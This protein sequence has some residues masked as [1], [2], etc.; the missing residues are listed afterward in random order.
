VIDIQ[1][2]NPKHRINTS[3]WASPAHA[4]A[5]LQDA[6]GIGE[7][8]N[9][10]VK[11]FYDDKVSSNSARLRFMLARAYARRH[12]G[13]PEVVKEHPR[14]RPD[15]HGG[16]SLSVFSNANSEESGMFNKR[17]R[18][19]MSA[20]TLRSITMEEEELTND[21]VKNN[22]SSLHVPVH[23]LLNVGPPLEHASLV[24]KQSFSNEQPVQREGV[25]GAARV[26][27]TRL[28]SRQFHTFTRARS[29]PNMLD[30]NEDDNN[31]DNRVEVPV[32]SC[33]L[34]E[35]VLRHAEGRRFELSTSLPLQHEDSMDMGT[36]S[37]YMGNYCTSLG[38]LA[39][40]L[41]AVLYEE[42]GRA[43]AIER[44]KY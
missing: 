42:H 32:G 6:V 16:A 21:D 26:D 13:S 31:N 10:E 5:G 22:L 37:F 35:Q 19:S 23:H 9:S 24:T 36:L 4:V 44:E 8:L 11:L 3:S 29:V 1:T 40:A 33:Q 17:L 27:V 43:L 15:S 39:E 20:Y 12:D 41:Q 18:R 14:M 25:R 38:V 30:L 7:H 28:S 2:H 34:D